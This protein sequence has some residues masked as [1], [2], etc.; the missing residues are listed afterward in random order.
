MTSSTFSKVLSEDPMDDDPNYINDSV[1]TSNQQRPMRST[2]RQKRFS[3]LTLRVK[4]MARRFNS[5][6]A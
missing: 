4:N 1:K 5:L 2:Q 6:Q 3:K